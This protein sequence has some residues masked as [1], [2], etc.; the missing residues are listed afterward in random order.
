MQ[1]DV[2]F[3]RRFRYQEM[4]IARLMCEVRLL[5]DDNAELLAQLEAARHPGTAAQA[6][7]GEAALPV[8][9]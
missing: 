2:S 5:R 6:D 4:A 3:E 1:S 7:R 9:R 8:S